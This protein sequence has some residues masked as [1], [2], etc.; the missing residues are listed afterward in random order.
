[1]VG[2]EGDP[3]KNFM[4]RTAGIW[5][6]KI[7]LAS[8]PTIKGFSRIDQSYELSDKS[9]YEVPCPHCDHGQVL[10]LGGKDIPYGIKW[11]GG[12]PYSAYY[13]CE[14]CGGVIRDYHKRDMLKQGAWRST[15]VPQDPRHK[16]FGE[17][18]QLY[19]PNIHFSSIA[20]DFLSCGTNPE[21][22]QVFFNDVIG[23]C[24]EDKGEGLS[25]NILFDRREDW[26]PIGFLPEGIA[27]LLGSADVGENHI[28]CSIEG[29]GR[30]MENWVVDYFLFEGDTLLPDIWE[31]LRKYVLET[32]PHYCGIQLRPMVFCI[33]SRFRG[34]MVAQFVK[35]MRQCGVNV[36]AIQGVE[37][38]KTGEIMSGTVPSK[39]NK[40]KVPVYTVNDDKAKLSVFG[41]LKIQKPG[42]GGYVHFPKADWCNAEYFDQLLSEKKVRIREKGVIITKWLQ[43]PGVRNEPLDCK[44]YCLAGLIWLQKHKRFD[45]DRAADAMLERVRE[46]KEKQLEVGKIDPVEYFKERAKK[47]QESRQPGRRGNWMGRLNS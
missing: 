13:L 40:Y 15:V 7:I 8:K 42:Q 18:S 17:L 27:M 29:W 14:Q 1:V 44:K 19:H 41:R 43:K 39:K 6:K 9:V 22:L 4:G 36:I 2:K 38:T 46:F 12:D 34:E 37:R 3:V 25:E 16:G 45:L 11:T 20:K 47:M 23:E 24:W 31:E 26:T 5:N 32:R 35:T 10:R 30:G 21:L 33:D 28:A